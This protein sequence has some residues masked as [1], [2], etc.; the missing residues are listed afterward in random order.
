MKAKKILLLFGIVIFILSANEI[1]A[2]KRVVVKNSRKSDYH[3]KTPRSKVKFNNN[4]NKLHVNSFKK[5]PNT[6]ISLKYRG[7][8]FHYNG[9]KYYRHYA[10]NY[11]NVIPPL[12]I[13]IRVLPS[14]YMT[15]IIGRRSYYY[16]DGVYYTK[17]NSGRVY[18]VVEA[19]I[20]AIV[21]YLPISAEA[22]QIDN[23]SF[24]A[25]NLT[26]Y[27]KIR[28]SQGHAYKVVGHL[29]SYGNHY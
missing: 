2:Q 24:F 25:C 8:N 29:K 3:T 13:Q 14:D 10:G 26:V 7:V 12:G 15:F 4:N 20:G 21:R 5:L 23:Q 11:I 1:Q 22:I 27:S 6:S 28:S 17:R 16:V 18:E 9:G 19:P